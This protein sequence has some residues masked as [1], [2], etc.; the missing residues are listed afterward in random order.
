M[1]RKLLS[2]LCAA[3]LLAAAGCQEQEAASTADPTETTAET[4]EM[5]S[6]HYGYLTGHGETDPGTLTK[7]FARLE[8]DGHTCEEITISDVTEEFDG[9][10]LS[11]PEED[12]TKEELDALDIYMDGGGHVLLLMPASISDTRYKYLGQFLEDYCITLDYD[13]IN[14]TASSN[15]VSNDSEFIACQKV[16]LPDTFVAYDDVYSA[17]NPFMRHARS[18]HVTYRTG[19]YSMLIDTMVQ[20]NT[21]A[22]G[23]PCG[24]VEDD[25]VSYEGEALKVM[26]YSQDKERAYSSVVAVGANDFLLDEHYDEETSSCMISYVYS[27]LAWF[28]L[29]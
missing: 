27:T 7:F 17:T 13:L 4:A 9:L 18:F 11:A 3:M 15:M 29:F 8:A 14:E 20:T 1:K 22:V 19:F 23:T 5:N 2:I 16:A 10:I 24:G 12:I 6:G 28:T 25:P 26:I 21:T